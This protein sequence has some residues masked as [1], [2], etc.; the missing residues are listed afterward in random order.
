MKKLNLK[1]HR[2]GKLIVVGEFKVIGKVSY[3]LCRCDCGNSKFVRM[4][5][6]TSGNST[7]CGC[8]QK[9]INAE[10][11][12]KQLT[13]HGMTKSREFKTWQSIQQRCYNKNDDHYKNYGGRGIKVCS[14]WIDSFLNFYDDMGRRPEGKSIDRI[15]NDGDY[16]P[17][18]CKWST[19]K[20]Q[21]N[22]Q[23]PRNRII[24]LN[25]TQ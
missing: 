16:T 4:G 15:N 13:T 20:E 11:G 23:R 3:W 7:T 17:E 25:L 24:N 9:I 8:I 19:P 6:L 21:R 5:N 12:R 22:N 14:R 18:N 10:R 1:G 2:F